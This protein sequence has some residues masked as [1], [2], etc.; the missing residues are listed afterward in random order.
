MKRIMIFAIISLSF[1]GLFA[2]ERL[3]FEKVI[4][5]DSIKK[6]DIYNGLK[7][8]VGMNFVSAK[9]VI[10]LDDK[11]AGLIIVNPLRDYTIGKLQ[12]LCYDGYIKYSIKMQIKEGRFKVVITN[13]MHENNPGNNSSCQ[14][15][16]ITTSVEYDGISGWGYK[17]YN[18]KVWLDVKKDCELIANESFKKLGEIIFSTSKIDSKNNNW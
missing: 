16:L 7:E 1:S 11:E 3:S 13:F 10:E 8:W 18:N 4:T 5:V 6:N 14:L 15:G 9:N 2:Q 17:S 12:Y